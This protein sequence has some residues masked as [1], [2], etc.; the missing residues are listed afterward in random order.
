MTQKT[1]TFSF[2][3]GVN[4]KD[5]SSVAKKDNLK[6][7]EVELRKLEDTTALIHEELLYMKE[8]ES[9]RRQAAG[10]LSCHVV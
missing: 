7:L 1:V 10:A 3:T 2:K 6:P 4:A 8:R 9:T 5:Y